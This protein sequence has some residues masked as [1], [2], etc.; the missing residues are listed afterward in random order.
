[1]PSQVQFSWNALGHW[2]FST[3]EE[4]T[5]GCPCFIHIT[6]LIFCMDH[7]SSWRP[8]H[9]M[10]K[11]FPSSHL[12][13]WQR[14]IFEMFYG[15]LWNPDLGTNQPIFKCKYTLLPLQN[16]QKIIRRHHRVNTKAWRRWQGSEKE[17][18]LQKNQ[19]NPQTTANLAGYL[20]FISWH[21]MHP[22]A[23]CEKQTISMSHPPAGHTSSE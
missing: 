18:E 6:Q 1:M 16:D 22:T 9:L 10:Q 8:L 5:F 19:K 14:G 3:E 4:M 2:F 23:L 20:D 13:Y 17:M 21:L 15:G 11:H 12:G 7:K